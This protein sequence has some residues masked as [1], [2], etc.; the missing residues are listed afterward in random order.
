[1]A[2]P[3]VRSRTR[4]FER[5]ARICLGIDLEKHAGKIRI[6]ELKVPLIVEFIKG[7]TEGVIVFQMKVVDFRFRSG[8]PTIL[9]HIHLKIE[10]KC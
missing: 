8:V 5:Y 4:F 3:P 1:M 7:G 10:I 9:T 6:C 2:D